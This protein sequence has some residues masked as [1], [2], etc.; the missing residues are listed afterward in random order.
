MNT[1]VILEKAM[2]AYVAD[3]QAAQS[4]TDIATVFTEMFQ[5]NPS[6]VPGQEPPVTPDEYKSDNSDYGLKLSGIKTREKLNEAAKEILSRVNKSEELNDADREVLKQ[7]SGRGG[8]TDNSQFEYYTPQ[9]VAEGCWDSL[10][11]NGFTSGN[12]L[13]PSTGHG[14]FEATKAKGVIITGCDIDPTSSKIAQLLNPD[15][16]IQNQS[17]EKLV[18][19]TPDNSFDAVIDDTGRGLYL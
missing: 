19:A 1:D 12:V 4:F 11:A 5:L 16:T 10:T 9:H 17:F 13:D 15:D 7:Y 2:P 6:Q 18:A 14:M 3:I 8:L